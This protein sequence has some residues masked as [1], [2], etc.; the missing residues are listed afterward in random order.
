MRVIHL[1]PTMTRFSYYWTRLKEAGVRMSAL[2]ARQ[3]LAPYAY[4]PVYVGKN[5]SP[6]D[7]A[8]EQAF[9][10]FGAICADAFVSTITNDAGRKDRI[11]ARL[12][13]ADSKDFP[14]L[15]YGLLPK[16]SEYQWHCDVVHDHT[17]TAKYFPRV[18]F[19]KTRSRSDVKIPWELS[20]LHWLLW[21]AEA[22]LIGNV[23][24]QRE[25]T[26]CLL[27]TLKD[28]R[29]ANPVA[30]GIN[31]VCGMEVAIRATNIAIAAGALAHLME[32][33]EVQWVCALLSAHQT[34]LHRF[35]EVSD[36]P[37]NHYLTDLM[38]EVVLHAALDGLLAGSTQRALAKF[39]SSADE[40]FEPCGCHIERAPV[41]HRL[42]YDIV[43]LPYAL[44]LRSGSASGELL[45]KVI[46]R[47]GQFMAQITDKAGSLPVYGDQDSG[48]VLWFEEIAQTVDKRI[49]QAPN[50][51]DTDLYT[52]MSALAKDPRFFPP[53]QRKTGN[54]SGFASIE[55]KG[56]FATLKTGPLG[57][58]GRA[59]HDHDDAL[60][61]CAS[62]HGERL[63]VDSGCHSYTLD[64]QLRVEFI[65]SSR[66]NSPT[67]A[68]RE[69]H[70]PAAGSINATMR[71]APTA[72]LVSWSD[73]T[74]TGILERTASSR[75]GL[76][77]SVQV[78]DDT[79]EISD[80]W[81]FDEAEAARITWLLDPAWNIDGAQEEGEIIAL[82]QKLRLKSENSVLSAQIST[83][84]AAT[85]SYH[86]ASFSPNY[87]A[88]EDCW[89]IMIQTE[90]AESGSVRLTV[91][92]EN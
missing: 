73:N 83:S 50:A 12:Q 24:A 44:A 26:E 13:L 55:G 38:G 78:L 52:F 67:P 81:T 47:A 84:N 91:S 57:L 22:A 63:L 14:V 49:C 34:Y 85:L 89:A 31:W 35:P 82:Q 10:D 43:A 28:W 62:W 76:E 56:F 40:Q 20:R 6:V 39:A 5:M 64:P 37:G 27:K 54:G 88:L 79:L 90:A 92:S 77:R 53:V 68:T 45:S 19:L 21:W 25:L 16:P 30:Y 42:T 60:A 2:K 51:P 71:G 41:Y 72:K 17:W 69:R 33:D 3:L 15:G 23:E 66:H 59:P 1:E 58:K 87:G 29:S 75:M 32:K 80:S 86:R 4:W 46:A 18:D 7:D 74:V 8:Q 48:F 36:V 70:P 11:A 61:V 65:V 9:R